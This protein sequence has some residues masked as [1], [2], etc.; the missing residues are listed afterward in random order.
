MANGISHLS[1]RPRFYNVW[2]FPLPAY[3]FRACCLGPAHIQRL[4]QIPTKLCYCPLV[5]FPSSL[6]EHTLSGS[7]CLSF[8]PRWSDHNIRERKKFHMKTNSLYYTEVL[9]IIH[10]VK[11]LKYNIIGLS[12]T[13]RGTDVLKSQTIFHYFALKINSCNC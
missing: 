3:I 4:M 10:I 1:L 9:V 8:L 5:V 13:K 7:T 6:C 2:K 12:N 11:T